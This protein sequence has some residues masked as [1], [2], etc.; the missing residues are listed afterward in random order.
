MV[1][2]TKEPFD[3]YIGRPGR[4]GNPFKQFTRKINIQ[5]YEEYL[6]NSPKLLKDLPYLKGQTLGCWCKP[7]PCHGDVIVKLIKEREDETHL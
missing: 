3:I 6:R 2:C 7:K 1:H 5:K 4:W